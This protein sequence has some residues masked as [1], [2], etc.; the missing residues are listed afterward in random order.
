MVV[1]VEMK[2]RLLAVLASMKNQGSHQTYYLTRLTAVVV[3]VV[4][5]AVV[6]AEKMTEMEKEVH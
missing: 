3:A 6:M 1:A 4:T 5:T 2:V